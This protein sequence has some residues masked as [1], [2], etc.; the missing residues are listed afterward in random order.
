MIEDFANCVPEIP[1]RRM[2]L[3]MG[4]EHSEIDIVVARPK[5][6]LFGWLALNNLDLRLDTFPRVV[7]LSN[8]SLH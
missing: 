1:A 7:P 4:A 3:S 6:D 5:P 2:V 8:D